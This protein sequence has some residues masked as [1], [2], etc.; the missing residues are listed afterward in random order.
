MDLSNKQHVADLLSALYGHNCSDID[1]PA[2]DGCKNSAGDNRVY[3]DTWTAELYDYCDAHPGRCVKLKI[4]GV[5]LLGVNFVL[6]DTPCAI[7]VMD[8]DTVEPCG[9]AMI[10]G[11]GAILKTP[12]AL[13]QAWLGDT[14]LDDYDDL[15]PIHNFAKVCGLSC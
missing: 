15:H 11:D 12:F 1:L 13:V 9:A 8:Y 5:Q 4:D 2:P 10:S 14:V 7:V 6:E 3:A